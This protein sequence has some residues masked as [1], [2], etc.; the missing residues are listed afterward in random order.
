[1]SA[2]VTNNDS[3]STNPPSVAQRNRSIRR[4][5]RYSGVLVMLS[6]ALLMVAIVGV[7]V[8]LQRQSLKPPVN[9]DPKKT[10]GED[11]THIRAASRSSASFAKIELEMQRFQFQI[12]LAHAI[13]AERRLTSVKTD[14]SNLLESTLRDSVGSRI[15]GDERL[16]LRFRAIQ[17]SAKSGANK[18]DKGDSFA[19]L[20]EIG[21][22][23]KDATGHTFEQLRKT[24]RRKHDSVDNAIAFYGQH[25]SY[26]RT[27]RESA[28]S[29]PQ[30]ENDLHS[31]IKLHAAAIASKAKATSGEAAI[32]LNASLDSERT[33]AIGERD[34]AAELVN[35]LE[36][37][38]HELRSGK[39]VTSRT[40]N[41]TNVPPASR[42]DYKRDFERIRVNLIAFTTP[43]YVQPKSA[44][45]LVF[46]KTKAP[47]SYS[48]LQRIGALD[49]TPVGRSIL[50]RV[51]G[52]KSASQQNDRPLGTFPRMNSIEQLKNDRNVKA[53]V[54]EAQRL[55][56]QYG[57][58][59]VE[60]DLLSP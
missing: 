47:I 37:Q 21:R 59:M 38:L 4:K 26:L 58:F 2:D 24:L 40:Q 31:A 53:R 6:M 19:S 17:Q 52:S 13:E 57:P 11:S 25:L 43:G 20:S 45:V 14:W 55:L 42:D 1:M 60:D 39:P 44:D 3:A 54:T 36:S 10:L 33:R 41:A 50:L 56:R 30:S 32:E 23:A 29:L 27:L 28:A 8:V 22:D 12:E 46:R 35:G 48:A 15:A 5:W 18:P 16:L 34:S 51:G 7:A 49:D 9:P